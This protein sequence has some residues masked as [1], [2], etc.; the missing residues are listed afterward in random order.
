V[1]TYEIFKAAVD[2]C[3]E[4][5]ITVE[6]KPDEKGKKDWKSLLGSLCQHSVKKLA[7]QL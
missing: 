7:K 6:T 2:E 3:M 4:S 1:K 5:V